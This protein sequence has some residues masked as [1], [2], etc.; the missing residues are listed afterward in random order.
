MDHIKCPSK[1][2]YT[3]ILTSNGDIHLFRGYSK[4]KETGHYS[5]ALS[6]ILKDVDMDTDEKNDDSKCS[7]CDDHNLKIQEMEKDLMRKNAEIEAL[8]MKRLRDKNKMQQLIQEKNEY[9]IK[10]EI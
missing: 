3:A 5:I 2:A 6:M 10:Y 8:T 9:A 4:F 7:M 1:S